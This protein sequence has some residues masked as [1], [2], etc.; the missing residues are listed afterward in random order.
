MP[1]WSIGAVS[2]TVMARAIVGSNPTM[3]TTAGAFIV[4]AEIS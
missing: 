4:D 2:K 1:E 3:L